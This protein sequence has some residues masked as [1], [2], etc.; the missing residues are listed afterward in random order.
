M[1][2]LP[3]FDWLYYF[4]LARA[5]GIGSNYA[6]SGRM[7]AG[8]NHLTIFMPVKNISCIFLRI[9]LNQFKEGNCHS[10]PVTPN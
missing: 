5:S 8:S 9:C 4:F 10:N 2:V 7:N 1:Y 3:G 6:L